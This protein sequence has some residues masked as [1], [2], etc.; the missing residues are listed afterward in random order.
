MTKMKNGSAMELVYNYLRDN[1]EKQKLKPGTS[2]TESQI[3]AA[4]NV[5]RSPVRRALQALAD[6]GYVEIVPNKGAS[7]VKFT[8]T[9]VKQLYAL[10]NELEMYSLRLTIGTYSEADLTYLEHCIDEQCNSFKDLDF[11]RYLDY[12]NKFHC[13][14]VDKA[15]NPYLSSMFERIM[16]RISVYLS[17]Y[18]NFYSVK[19]LKTLPQHRKILAGIRD[20][21]LNKV[22]RATEELD[23]RI[24]DVYDYI[25]LQSED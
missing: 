20:G 2:I 9:Q 25:T 23:R 18:D 12:V 15:N 5:G 13:Y 4:I 17:L 10:R 19:Q 3:C 6:D 1:I 14:I 24:I 11:N 22:A 8:Q 21:K 16:S 7:V